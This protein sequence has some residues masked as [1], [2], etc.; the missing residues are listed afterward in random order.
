MRIYRCDLC[1]RV[2]DPVEIHPG[3]YGTH[4]LHMY[5]RTDTDRNEGPY[6]EQD[7]CPKCNEAICNY[8]LRLSHQQVDLVNRQSLLDKLSDYS[9]TDGVKVKYVRQWI[10]DTDNGQE[11]EE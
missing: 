4:R 10:T 5:G 9:D 2:Y 3:Y 7:I 11:E 8:T 6:F 1:G